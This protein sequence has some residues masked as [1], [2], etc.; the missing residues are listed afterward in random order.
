MM[1]LL[2]GTK[3]LSLGPTLVVLSKYTTDIVLSPKSCLAISACPRYLPSADSYPCTA[4]CEFRPGRKKV[5]IRMTNFSK[6]DQNSLA[7]Y[8]EYQIRRKTPESKKCRDLT[9]HPTRVP[10]RATTNPDCAGR[11]IPEVGCRPFH[12]HAQ[13]NKYEN[14]QRDCTYN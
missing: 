14:K 10:V 4:L 12:L 6:T 5:R 13:Q 3:T 2:K 7:R 11:Y 1:L 8:T 9:K